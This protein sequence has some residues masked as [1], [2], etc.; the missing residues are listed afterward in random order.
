LQSIVFQRFEIHVQKDNAAEGW[1]RVGFISNS[2]YSK[3]EAE[4]AALD[5]IENLKKLP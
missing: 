4:K 3:E 5:E 1:E 2:Y